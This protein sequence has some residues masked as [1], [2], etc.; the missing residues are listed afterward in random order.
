MPTVIFESIDNRRR[1]VDAPPGA[2]LMTAAVGQG[3]DG[4]EADCGGTCSCATC[5][6]YIDERFVDLLPPAE[7][8]ELDMLEFVAAERRPNSRLSCQIVVDQK[9]EGLLVRLPEKQVA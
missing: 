2:S 9:L 8:Q 5:H 4:I 1:E 3:V 6:V 7:G